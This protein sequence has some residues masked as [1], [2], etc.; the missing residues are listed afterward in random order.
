MPPVNFNPK[1]GNDLLERLFQRDVKTEFNGSD[2]KDTITVKPGRNGGVNVT[3]NGETY[4]VPKDKVKDIVINAGA[5]ND[6]VTVDP[7]VKQGIT[8]NGGDGRDTIQ[9]GS[10]DDVID[11]GKGRDTIDGGR[12]DDHIYGGDGRDT[13][14]GGRGD[15]HIWGGKGR[16]TI[17]GGPGDDH[18]YGGDGWDKIKGG[19]GDDHVEQGGPNGRFN[20]EELLELL[21]ARLVR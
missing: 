2:G 6:N 18:I 14:N 13:I 21:R 10:G 15:D 11:G 7:R 20:L 9:G 12:G 3:V 17:D 4:Y 8:I 5:G 1:V 19:R 16:D